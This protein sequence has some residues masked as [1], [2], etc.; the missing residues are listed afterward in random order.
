MDTFAN[1][2]VLP[3]PK[4][5]SLDLKHCYHLLT[6]RDYVM[7]EIHDILQNKIL[8]NQLIMAAS[9]MEFTSTTQKNELFEKILLQN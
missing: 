2:F 6:Y 4:L 9:V 3:N 8:R 1:H 5:I 7:A